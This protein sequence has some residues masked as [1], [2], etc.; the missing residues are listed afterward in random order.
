MLVVHTTSYS[1]DKTSPLVEFSPFI[2]YASIQGVK[3]QSNKSDT[4]NNSFRSRKTGAKRVS[5][6]KLWFL[7]WRFKILPPK[8]NEMHS[9]KSIAFAKSR[10]SLAY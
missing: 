9:Y 8:K 10:I 4:L 7:A 1:N 5:K 6:L 3:M 2:K